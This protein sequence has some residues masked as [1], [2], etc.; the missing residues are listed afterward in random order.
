MPMPSRLFAIFLLAVA[1]F[2]SAAV[3]APA[4]DPYTAEVPV[5]GVGEGERDVAIAR[6]LGEVAVQVSGDPNAATKVRSVRDPGAL[7]SQYR[8]AMAPDGSRLLR[9]AFDPGA[10]DALL[11]DKGLGG[12]SPAPAASRAAGPLPSLLLWVGKESDGSRVLVSSET[13]PG[14][15]A[16]AER[17]AAASGLPLSLPLGDLED[18]ERLPA[19]ALWA[20]DATLIESASS[21]YGADAVLAGAVTR[22]P[23]EDRWRGSWTLLGG[24]A[25]S[26]TFRT[27]G[28]T[29]A[30]ATGRAVALAAGRLAAVPAAAPSE[31]AA[32]IPAVAPVAPPV[33][34]P[35]ERVRVQVRGVG[36]LAQHVRVMRLLQTAEGVEAAHT[37]AL[38]GDVLLVDV[39]ARGG[40]AQVERLVQLGFL[41][42]DAIAPAGAAGPWSFADAR[43]RYRVRQ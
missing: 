4:G 16:A 27:D 22:R 37:R 13:D 31:V 25:G 23:G 36:S 1:S 32:E 3:A 33:S 24:D 18:Q 40:P 9:V 11:R 15:G 28:A 17:A 35:T 19:Q 5:T 10:V 34:G 14:V 7:V 8:Y 6:A 20:G 30:E 39:T 12:V 2:L 43:L 41:E 26:Q 29:A 38:R 21:R 42:P